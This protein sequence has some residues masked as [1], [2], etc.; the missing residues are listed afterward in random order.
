MDGDLQHPPE[1]LPQLVQ[2]W[3]EGN[4]IVQTVR[5]STEDASF[6]KN[7]TSFVYYKMINAVSKV[8]ITP[9][10]SDF[11]LMD[12]HELNEKGQEVAVIANYFLSVDANRDSVTRYLSSVDQLI[13]ARIWL[14]DNHFELIAASERQDDSNQENNLD[15]QSPTEIKK[16]DNAQ[17]AV[18]SIGKQI[19]QSGAINGQV[20]KILS[21]VYA[22]KRV[23]SRIFHPY[24]KEQVLLVGLPVG[25][26]NGNS[27]TGAIL[28]ASP[29]SG[30]DKVLND[31]YLYTIIVGILALIFSLFLVRGL[32]RRIVQPLI[33]MK[34]SASAIAAGDYNRKVE[35]TGDD[36]IA[37]L[38]KSLNSL[39]SDL[40]EFVQ[41]TNK[42]E[43]LRRDF[44]A[45]VSHDFTTI[46]ICVR[47]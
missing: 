20:E 28:L 31:I 7:I 24:Y 3:E 15:P 22:G 36:E 1:L 46:G 26:E 8:H 39:G 30:L 38:G 17:K 34:D 18:A 44:V 33:S 42:M 9:G 4:E 45:N 41:K 10:G 13:G 16:T 40:D 12:R 47:S 5:K 23:N 27:K 14:F 19:K 21:D 2:L 25:D 6:F 43:K 11:R 37:E 32:S 35:V 29:I